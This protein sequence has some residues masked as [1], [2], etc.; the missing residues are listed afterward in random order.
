MTETDTPERFAFGRDVVDDC[1]CPARVAGYDTTGNLK[2]RE[3]AGDY[4]VTVRA[5]F[6]DATKGTLSAENA[7]EAYLQALRDMEE[8]YIPVPDGEKIPEQLQ[9]AR[10][11][12]VE[13]G[14]R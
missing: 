9:I 6:N 4:D 7:K 13:L 12:A 3:I 8:R 14:W 10:E 2:A 1:P 5:L 11:I